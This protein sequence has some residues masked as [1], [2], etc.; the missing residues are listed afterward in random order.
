MIEGWEK[1]LDWFE[2]DASFHDA[3]IVELHLHRAGKSWKRI[4]W[5]VVR[6][7]VDER[8]HYVC[9]K[10]ATVTLRMYEVFE[11][12]LAGF[13]QQNVLFGM[14]ASPSEEGIRI[15]LEPCHGLAGIITAK[16]ITA[17]LAPGRP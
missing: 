17:E 5:W 7:E 15:E 14:R 11:L 13:N 3:E 16:R 8:G 9:D 12:D 2:G 4:H 10:H 6:Q 1:V